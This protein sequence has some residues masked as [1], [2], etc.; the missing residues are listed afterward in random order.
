MV[1]LLAVDLGLRIAFATVGKLGRQ[2][3][4]GPALAFYVGTWLR[5]GGCW[6]GVGGA[7]KFFQF[8]QQMCNARY[9]QFGT[10]VNGQTVGAPIYASCPIPPATLP[11]A[12][13]GVACGQIPPSVAYVNTST[14]FRQVPMQNAPDYTAILGQRVSTGPTGTGI[15]AVE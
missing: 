6:K 3:R 7:S 10:I 13:A 2:L 14:I 4:Q 8:I 5:Q 11:P 9:L 1:E 12:Y 15:C